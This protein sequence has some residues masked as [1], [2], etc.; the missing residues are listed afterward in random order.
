MLR[1][2][3]PADV[4]SMGPPPGSAVRL[5]RCLATLM[6]A[7]DPPHEVRHHGVCP[8]GRSPPRPGRLG[9]ARSWRY[10]QRRR[11]CPRLTPPSPTS[12]LRRSAP[13]E[14]TGRRG[15]ARDRGAVRAGRRRGTDLPPGHDRHP[16]EL[17]RPARSR[18]IGLYAIALSAGAVLGQIAGGV[19]ISAAPRSYPSPDARCWLSPTWLSASPSSPGTAA[20]LCW[21]RCSPPEGSDSERSSPP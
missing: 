17:R 2:S 3:P 12:R 4:R 11:F 1:W 6:S 13:A 7:R 15:R 16:A 19:L 8:V 5:A 18:A 9:C 14:R 21:P 20:T 10:C